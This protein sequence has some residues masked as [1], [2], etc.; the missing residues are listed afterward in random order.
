MHTISFSQ[1][2]LQQ[3]SWLEINAVKM[4]LTKNSTQIVL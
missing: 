4:M 2:V 3:V 1:E